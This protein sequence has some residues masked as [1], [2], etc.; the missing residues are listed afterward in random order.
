MVSITVIGTNIDSGRPLAVALAG[1]SFGGNLLLDTVGTY[2]VVEDVEPSLPLPPPE[3]SLDNVPPLP[4]AYAPVGY[5]PGRFNHKSLP[6]LA[7]Q[8]STSLV[9]TVPRTLIYID[10]RD[11]SGN[12]I[13]G[14]YF[15]P[16][17]GVSSGKLVLK[18]A[19]DNAGTLGYASLSN[20]FA[21]SVGNNAGVS[22]LNN[23]SVLETA[24]RPLIKVG[25]RVRWLQR[26]ANADVEVLIGYVLNTPTP[27]EQADGSIQLTVEIGDILALKELD[28]QFDDVPYCGKDPVTAGDAAKIYAERRGLPILEYPPG[29]NLVE[30]PKDFT[31]ETP[32]SFLEKLYAPSNR[33]VGTDWRGQI[34]LFQRPEYDDDKAFVFTYADTLRTAIANREIK[35]YS[36]LQVY[37]RYTRDYGY[38]LWNETSIQYNVIA[39]TIGTLEEMVGTIAL[40]TPFTHNERTIVKE[41]TTYLGSSV[42]CQ[43]KETYGWIPVEPGTYN[44]KFNFTDTEIITCNPD[45]GSFNVPLL[46][47]KF[48]LIRREVDRVSL[49]K[50]DSGAYLVRGRANL[51][52]G[53]AVKVNKCVQF[54]TE[55]QSP[56]IGN[57]GDPV[58]VDCYFLAPGSLLNDITSYDNLKP[59]PDPGA[60]K[61]DWKWIS[62]SEFNRKPGDEASSGYLESQIEYTPLRPEAIFEGSGHSKSQIY[63]KTEKREKIR[64]REISHALSFSNSQPYKVV[65]TASVEYVDSPPSAQWIRSR[66]ADISVF[67]KY[68][69]N[70]YVN[71]YGN[72]PAKPIEAPFCFNE[73]QAETYAKR[74]LDTNN[75]LHESV[76]ITIPYYKRLNTG[77]SIKYFD[78]YGNATKGIVWSIEVNQTRNTATQTVLILKTVF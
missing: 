33:D 4:P 65:D 6:A 62:L 13:S 53:L 54:L 34:R 10:E 58:E 30:P 49:W 19:A 70:R 75:G 16:L 46:E 2:A 28:D 71:R 22:T 8:P 66:T 59:V 64:Q 23:F 24:E 29:T 41:T 3:P 38:P 12:F 18:E 9:T 68:K 48:D 47:C 26:F 44:T 50:H 35:P 7:T 32:F 57:T 21:D 77:S 42:I 51:V 56:C 63:R 37:N 11:Y 55:L 27:E 36:E 45:N 20:N 69:L 1:D 25:D 5:V 17:H 74:W 73:A 61:K 78:Q 52:A 14:D 60:C 72:K 40:E 31:Q 39:E 67:G 43:I 76:A 15:R